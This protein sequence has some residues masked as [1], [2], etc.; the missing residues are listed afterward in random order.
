[1]LLNG[2]FRTI[3]ES[4]IESRTT[5]DESVSLPRETGRWVCDY[6]CTPNDD[7]E[8]SGSNGRAVSN[9]SRRRQ[10]RVS[11]VKS[12]ECQ[13]YAGREVGTVAA[14]RCFHKPGIHRA[15][16]LR[17]QRTANNCHHKRKYLCAWGNVIEIHILWSY[18]FFFVGEWSRHAIS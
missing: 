2:F 4:W 15:F 1:M 18:C 13:D 14:Q 5:G 3:R 8:N 7:G 12:F 17:E 10:G 11:R 9:G 6:G 16:S